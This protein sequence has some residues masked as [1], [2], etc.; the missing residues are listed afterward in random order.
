MLTLVCKVV[1]EPVPILN[2]YSD[3][4]EGWQVPGFRMLLV[5][6]DHACPHWS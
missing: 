4:R 2:G 5:A 3:N 6:M 1:E